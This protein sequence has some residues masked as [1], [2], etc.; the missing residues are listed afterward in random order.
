MKKILLIYLNILFFNWLNA[1]NIVP[2]YREEIPLSKPVAN[3]ETSVLGADGKPRIRKVSEPTLTVF[4]PSKEQ[5]NGAA[6]IIC[7]GGGYVHLSIVG[8]GYEVAQLLNEWGV[9]AFVLKYR[10]PDDST[11]Q[12]KEIGPLQ[13]AQRAIQVVRQNAKEWNINPAK[14]G[15]MGFSAG[16]HLAATLGTHFNKALIP[17]KPKVSLRPDF[18]VLVYPVISVPD[19]LSRVDRMFLGANITPKRTKEYLKEFKVTKQTP[20]TFL[21]HA[22]DDKAVDVKNSTSFYEKLRKNGVPAE[23]HLYEKGGHGFGLNNRQSE[24]KWT[25][26]LRVWLNKQ[27]SIN[28]KSL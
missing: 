20:P 26:W 5:S 2:L 9:A 7:P 6:V 8:E 12:Q 18:M 24:E 19:S 21:E 15:I 14:V 11:M 10:L 17:N 4:L 13:D 22:K 27:L 25:D 3:R 1:Q 23:I 28:T 16:G